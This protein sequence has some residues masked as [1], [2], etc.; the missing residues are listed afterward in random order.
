MGVMEVISS[1]DFGVHTTVG[2]D[3][4]SE[5]LPHAYRRGDIDGLLFLD[6]ARYSNEYLRML[7]EDENFGQR[8][9]VGLV[10][11]IP[12]CSAVYSDH[13]SAGYAVAGHLLELGHQHVLHMHDEEEY[14]HR[15]RLSAYR[16]AYR[17]RDLDPDT[18]LHNCLWSSDGREEFQRKNEEWVMAA[19][20]Q[21]PQ[22]TAICARNDFSAVRIWNILRR[23]GWRVPEDIS[24]ISYDDTDPIIGHDGENILTTVH[25]PLIEVG[26]EA[27]RMLIRRVRGEETAERNILL[28]TKLV[29]RN[30]TA[31]P[32][33]KP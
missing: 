13:F 4:G 9:I 30:S 22:V 8:P 21:S 18:Y 11:P 19:L 26:E 3:S 24:L 2:M 17:V 33:R 28:P 23:H 20:S 10:D 15:L 31:P 7:R 14:A 32:R 6:Q 12:G 1:E 16:Q 27:T 5:R 25:L 29:V